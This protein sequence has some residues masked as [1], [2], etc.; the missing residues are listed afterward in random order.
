MS[1][2]MSKG[3][4]T[5]DDSFRSQSQSQSQS[6]SRSSP[7][8]PTPPTPPAVVFSYTILLLSLYLAASGYI[9]LNDYSQ[10]IT[11]KCDVKTCHLA[12][13]THSGTLGEGTEDDRDSMRV[14][15][16]NMDYTRTTTFNRNDYDRS[17]TVRINAAGDITKTA[18]LKRRQMRKLG[19]SYTL[20]YTKKADGT[21]GTD[22][23]DDTAAAGESKQY[24]VVM[25][26]TN[27]GKRTSRE[28]VSLLNSKFRTN[29]KTIYVS[30][31]K[32]YHVPSVVKLSVGVMLFGL[33]GLIGE[34]S[35]HG[36]RERYAKVND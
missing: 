27:L 30:E 24:E 5:F 23:T 34:W 15:V 17:A 3:L 10:A 29:T 22:G 4:P 26:R 25:S 19:Y 18:N 2:G 32:A 14:P 35:G 21:D 1:K 31:G 13:Y 9:N 33:I 11:L 16:H 6:R 28:R 12:T 20:L 36:Y 8:P 7:S